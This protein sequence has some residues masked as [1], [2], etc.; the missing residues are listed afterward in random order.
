MKTK[1]WLHEEIVLVLNSIWQPVGWSTPA[2]VICPLCTKPGEE[3]RN[4]VIDVITDPK[5]GQIIDTPRYTWEDWV[6]LPLEPRHL[7]ILTRS[8]AIRCPTLVTMTGYS[9]MPLQGKT[10]SPRAIRERDGDTCQVSGRKLKP[11]EGNMG[12]L[13]A[14]AKGG[15]RTFDNIVYMDKHLNLLQGTRTVEEMGWSLIKPAVPPKPFPACA[16]IKEAKLPEHSP[17]LL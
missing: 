11:G 16:S 9:Q 14:K 4:F 7:P 12:H 5:T 17:F 10:F 2:D 3:P 6:Q 8:G 13:I 1:S 15:K